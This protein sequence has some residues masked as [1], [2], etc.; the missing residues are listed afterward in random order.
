MYRIL[1]ALTPHPIAV[2]LT[3]VWYFALIVVILGCTVI[4]EQAVFRYVEL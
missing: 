1:A 2:A 3:A 4:A